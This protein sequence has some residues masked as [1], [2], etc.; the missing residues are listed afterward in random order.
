[1]NLMTFSQIIVI[2]SNSLIAY[3]GFTTDTVNIKSQIIFN[4]DGFI[5]NSDNKVLSFLTINSQFDKQDFRIFY[6]TG[7]TLQDT[8]LNQISAIYHNEK[9]GNQ[10]VIYFIGDNIKMMK[11]DKTYIIFKKNQN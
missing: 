3:N 10:V 5:I 11:K 4:K 9:Y 2:K 1:M 6:D 8:L 7:H